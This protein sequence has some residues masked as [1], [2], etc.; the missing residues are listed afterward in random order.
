MAI[1]IGEIFKRN[2]ETGKTMTSSIAYG[3]GHMRWY[4]YG[5][6][7]GNENGNETSEGCLRGIWASDNSVT[8]RYR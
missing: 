5:G 2:G 8:G 3:D 1:Q 7:N 6:G 4:D